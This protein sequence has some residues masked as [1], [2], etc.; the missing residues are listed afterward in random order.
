MA[1]TCS[2]LY[3]RAWAGPGTWTAGPLVPPDEQETRG[4]NPAP[5]L[6]PRLAP[7]T[8]GLQMLGCQSELVLG[9][10][11]G[12]GGGHMSGSDCGLPRSVCERDA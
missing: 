1:P 3:V 11:D 6:C 2:V 8:K 9:D 12:P 10:T 7:A 5:W 4:E